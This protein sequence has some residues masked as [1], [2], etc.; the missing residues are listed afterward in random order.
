MPTT[1]NATIRYQAIDRCLRNP[2]CRYNIDIK[3]L[4]R[5]RTEALQKLEKLLK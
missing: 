3:E 4:N 1:K 5:Q 2:G